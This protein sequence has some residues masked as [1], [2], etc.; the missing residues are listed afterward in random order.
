MLI[1]VA[2]LAFVQ[3]WRVQ[4]EFQG[5]RQPAGSTEDAPYMVGCYKGWLTKYPFASIED[6]I[7]RTSGTQARV[8]W[9]LWAARSR[10]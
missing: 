9:M 4:L 8:S 3:G 2:A 5:S 10:S 6:L 7:D 1:D